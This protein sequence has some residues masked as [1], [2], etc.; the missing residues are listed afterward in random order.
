MSLVR[1]EVSDSRSVRLYLV[2]EF[3][4][5]NYP[6]LSRGL[7]PFKN[8]TSVISPNGAGKSNLMD[9]ISFVLGVRSARL[10]S[11]QLKDLVY[12]RRRLARG[13]L[14]G[15]DATQDQEGD[16]NS[17]GK[18]EGTAKKACVLAA[19]HR[20]TMKRERSGYSNE[21]VFYLV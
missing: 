10:R 2:N 11:S 17:D 19:F 16:D 4:R 20:V 12:R 6:F 3:H 13:A 1:I 14:D 5:S 18:A 8:F 9:A 21:C 7:G 15:S